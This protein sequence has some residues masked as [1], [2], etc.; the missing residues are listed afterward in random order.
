MRKAFLTFVIAMLGSLVYSQN[1]IPANLI[2]TPDTGFC[3]PAT[4]DIFANGGGGCEYTVDSIPYNFYTAGGTSVSMSDDQILGPFSIGFSFDF[5]CNTYTQFYICSNGWV[6]FSSGQTSTW[7]VNP[8]PSV[9]FNRPKNCVMAP[10]RDW[11]P[12]VGSGP[13]ITYQTQGTAPFRRLVVTWSSVPMFSCTTTYGTFQVVLYETTNLI[14]N[15]L[16][17]VPTCP[18][19]GNGDGVQAIHNSNGTDAEIVASRN[20]NSFT[21]TNESWRYNLPQI[22]WVYDGDT[23]GEG[24][25]LEISPANGVYPEECE[26]VYAILDS[27]NG[28]IAI[29]SVLLSPY[30]KIPLFDVEDVLCHGDTTGNIIVEDTN[31]SATYPM[32]FY[33]TNSAGDTI[34]SVIKNSQFDTLETVGVGTYHVTIVDASGCYITSGSADVDE[35]DTLTANIINATQVSCPGGL[36]CDASAQANGIGGVSPFM[37][38]WSSGETTQ[39]ANSLCPDTNYVTITDANGCIAETYVIIG[40]PQEIVTDGFTDTMIC[41]TNPA[42]L[43]AASTGGTQP[44]S[45]V[46]TKDSL[47]GAVISTSAFATV[48]PDTTTQYFVYSVDGN[49]CPGDTAEVLVKVRPPLSSVIEPVDTIC[50]YD[51]IDMS[52]EAFGGDSIYTYS[53]SSGQFGPVTTVSPDEPMW[54]VLTVSDACGTP[55]YIDSVFVQVGGYSPIDAKLRVEDDSI[56][57]GENVYLIASGRGGWKGPDE[58]VF[59]WSEANMDGNPI[60]FVRPTSTKT[61]SVTISDLCLS[62]PGVANLTVHVG[63][64]Y[65]PPFL[66][67]PSVSCTE[68]D[69]MI[70]FGNY[71]QGYQYTWN[72]GDGETFPNVLADSVIHRYSEPG[73]YDVKLEVISDFGCYATRT[74]NCLVKILQS[75]VAAYDHTPENPSTLSPFVKFTDKSFSAK[76]V[77]WY[78]NGDSLSLDSI[79]SYEFRDTGIYEVSLVAIS[80][81]GCID[82]ISKTLYNKLDQTLYIPSSFTPN[83]DG[84]ND[85]FRIVGEGIGLEYYELRVFDRWGN[86]VFY[87]KNP[88]FGWDGKSSANGE[89]VPSGAYAFTLRYSDRNGEIRL[90]RGQVIVSASGKYQGLR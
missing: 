58:Y 77:A 47:T 35:P 72:F 66:A 13:Y 31:T 39:I 5:Y 40:V 23:V 12:A 28:N 45:Y 84:L 57:V 86:V 81:D 22:L 14:D 10:W 78:L 73:C 1:L 32:T 83:E 27:A 85:V 41:I 50:P 59:N 55:S 61:Y 79:F 4:F 29:D 3:P 36:T 21:A 24:P 26:Y 2:S 54:Y 87:S 65:A 67:T 74:E 51:T 68:T 76:S 64:P 7:V 37:F 42:S 6:G 43:A 44:F 16:S 20:D 70:S 25:S 52:A 89:I 48:Y 19:W 80:K 90:H 17:N 56:C 88:E 38:S 8:V 18:Q 9:L 11:N 53:W 46:W 75:P 33:W 62:E 15:N 69:V 82:T 60:Q 71:I 49:G 30:C 63:E 34:K